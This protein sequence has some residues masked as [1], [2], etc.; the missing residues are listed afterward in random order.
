MNNEYTVLPAFYDALNSDV[1][2]GEYAEYILSNVSTVT[3]DILDLGCG[4]GELTLA[5]S[6]KGARVVG[7]DA[8][9]EMLTLASN[10]AIRCGADAFFTCQDMSSFSTGKS[11]D[12]IISTF[13]S[14]NYLKSRAALL[15]TFECVKRELRDD[16]VFL[17]DMNSEYKF[18]NVYSDNSYILEGDGVFCA[19]ANFFDEKTKKCD[20]YID[21]FAEEKRGLYKRYSETQTER[22][23][24][25][26]EIKSSIKK[27]GL[28]L[29]GVF[30][31]YEETP[32]SDNTERY[33]FKVKK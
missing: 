23:F 21:V 20:F 28:T 6:K 4:T 11:Y 2:Y 14:L 33:Y 1:D 26:Q 8:S 5:L 25:L 12:A 13:D 27:A 19:W 29:I 22:M 9:T 17:F 10:K 7:L 30:S 31:D 16:G 32:I 18:R 15:R 24:T 3:P